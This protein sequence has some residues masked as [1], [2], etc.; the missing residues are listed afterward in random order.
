[1]LFV[2]QF[3]VAKILKSTHNLLRNREGLQPTEAFDS[4]AT[5]FG[6][7]LELG[8]KE[9]DYKKLTKFS[10]K[11]K[12]PSKCSEKSFQIISNAF[13][14]VLVS[15]GD[16]DFLSAG[17]RQFTS[18]ST[19]KSLGIFL[20][21][22]IICDL[23]VFTASSLLGRSENLTI[24]DPACGAGTFLLSVKKFFSADCH[25]IGNDISN[26]MA[27]LAK[28]NLTANNNLIIKQFDTLSSSFLSKYKAKFDLIVTNPPFGSEVLKE[29]NSTFEKLYNA[30]NKNRIPTELAFI[31]R[32]LDLL[33]DN[34]ILAIVV[35][36]GV[37]TNINELFTKAR[38]EFSKTGQV[39]GMFELPSETFYTTGTQSNTVL[40]FIKKVSN[41]A[42]KSC[43]TWRKKITTIGFDGTGRLTEKNE[44][45]DIIS[46]LKENKI[47]LKTLLTTP[48]KLNGWE[49]L[50]PSQKSTKGKKIGDLCDLVKTGRTP[51]RSKYADEGLFIVKVGNLTGKGI[52]FEARDR[53]FVN[54]NETVTRYKAGLILQA[55][56]LLLTSSAHAPK[57][58]A[59]KVDIY[60]PP[61]ESIDSATFVGEIMM[62]RP[63]KI[64]DPFR[65]LFL[66]RLKQI[67]EYLSDSVIGQTA[68]LSPDSILDL[69]V[70]ESFFSENIG[71]DS[72]INILKEESTASKKQ[73]ERFNKLHL[74]SK[75]FQNLL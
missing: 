10:Q 45:K 14:D 58:I 62:I 59:K 39:I 7:R 41:E 57:Y 13:R 75:K 24:G 5:Y 11:N 64:I 2:D 38:K 16:F 26:R 42:S 71:I 34:G 53:N 50:K 18:G 29:D 73:F 33:V 4:I 54:V 37:F 48:S 9:L 51:S 31:S 21:P 40:A 23:A 68:H 70:D 22:E 28:L 72:A 61:Y 63:K 52:N 74:I 32:S 12:I 3:E 20:T 44:A 19:R 15:K 27:L 66:F 65:L 56:D 47:D 6:A 17:L 67:Q 69:K 46:Q 43:V 30:T 8:D 25:V 35:Q 49:I 60:N 1:M 55:G 36:K